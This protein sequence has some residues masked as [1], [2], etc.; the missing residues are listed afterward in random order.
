MP[1]LVSI[2][3]PLYNHEKFIYKAVVSVLEQTYKN[4]ELII[5]D[6]GSLD[7]SLALVSSL[8]DSRIKL[9]TQENS[10]AHTTIN[11]GIAYAKGD[12]IAILNSDDFYSPVRLQ[13]LVDAMATDETIDALFS[14]VEAI[15]EDDGHFF[16]YGNRPTHH[17]PL[18][19]SHPDQRLAADLL[20]SNIVTTTSNLFCKKVVFKDIGQFKDYRYC[21]DLDFFLKLFHHKHVRFIN[22]P[23]LCYRFHSTNT[24]K[25]DNSM[26]HFETAIVLADFLH[27]YSP[28]QIFPKTTPDEAHAYLFSA[29]NI[30]H[31]DRVLHILFQYSQ[32]ENSW[33]RTKA[34]LLQDKSHPF[35]I[36]C[37]KH[38]Q[39]SL[40]REDKQN[41][42][43]TRLK[44]LSTTI[45]RL[46]QENRLCYQ[47]ISHRIG[48]CCTWPVRIL[49]RTY[50]R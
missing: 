17:I 23:L 25:E 26:V 38:I 15:H 20:G 37:L 10:G 46:S 48:R 31:I 30:H 29:L 44:Q 13:T 45:E 32:E 19:R 24:I 22:E 49:R 7:N 14:Q 11:R 41:K 6:D 21:H 42:T 18:K 3:I 4:L 2:I 47:S 9:Y 5:I 50:K 27:T 28:Q 1:P 33:Q 43:E 39:D 40:V 8:S 36:A 16:S 34:K 12:Y 35:R